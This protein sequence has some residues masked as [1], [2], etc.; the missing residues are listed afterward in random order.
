MGVDADKFSPEGHRPSNSKT[1]LYVGR[2][3]KQKGIDVLFQAF[4]DVVRE[5]PEARLD[6]IGYG[7]ERENIRKLVIAHRLEKSVS[8][9]D[10]VPHDR[11]PGIYRRARVLL[12]PSLIPEGLGMTPAEAGLCGV[13]TITFGLGGTKEI[14]LDEETGLIVKPSKEALTRAMIRVLTDDA[15]ADSLGANSRRFLTGKIGW[16]GVA[17]QFNKLFMDISKGARNSDLA[18]ETGAI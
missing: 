4:I 16:Q 14:V 7:P 1:A 9:I 6:I 13:P 5:I 2:L 3:I 11:L 8:I 17:E 15:L 12:L 18:S 10:M